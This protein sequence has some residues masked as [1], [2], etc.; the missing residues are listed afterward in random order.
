MKKMDSGCPYR[1]NTQMKRLCTVSGCKCGT[2][3][4]SLG[5]CWF[6]RLME[7]LDGVGL[8]VASNE[9]PLSGYWELAETPGK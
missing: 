1:V 6:P 2:N 9:D 4:G 8:K 3:L 5:I 7:G